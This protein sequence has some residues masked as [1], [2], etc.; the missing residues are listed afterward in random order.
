M[1]DQFPII[2][3][4]KSEKP[5]NWQGGCLWAS[6]GVIL[7]GFALGLVFVIASLIRGSQSDV[8]M[9]PEITVIVPSTSTPDL[10]SSV[11]EDVDL[12][13]TPLGTPGEDLG[14]DLAVGNIVEVH[15]TQGQGLS[16]R[17][18]PG[19]SSMVDEYGLENEIFEIK[20]GPINADGY[21]WWFLVNIYN[22]SKQG[23]A[24]GVYLRETTP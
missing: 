3:E 20:G 1:T 22:N 13:Q 16:L 4:P 21:I 24:V 5:A 10:H 7:G 17:R 12:E 11:T 8:P 15:G 18:E 6:I 2:N 14:G 23:W 9:E 19:L